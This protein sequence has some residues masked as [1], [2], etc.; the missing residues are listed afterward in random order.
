MSRGKGLAALVQE[1]VMK[2]PERGKRSCDLLDSP[3]GE[4]PSIPP[5]PEE[6]F[7]PPR[8]LP[9]WTREAIGRFL[10]SGS[11]RTKLWALDW[12]AEHPELGEGPE[13]VGAV[14]SLLDNPDPFILA[15]TFPVLRSL[16]FLSSAGGIAEL[17]RER[18]P[19][20]RPTEFYEQLIWSLA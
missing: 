12:V 14:A 6:E 17:L 9:A 19:R 20:F 10:V 7:L 15:S 8:D 2:L 16:K 4:L 13:I 1:P 5:P 18:L 11:P 3:S